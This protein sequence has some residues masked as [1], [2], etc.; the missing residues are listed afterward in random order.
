MFSQVEECNRSLKWSIRCV[1]DA[2][3]CASNR[4]WEP[5]R[6]S[7]WAMIYWH[8]FGVLRW[9]PC[10]ACL[11]FRYII[12]IL[13][14]W[15]QLKSQRLWMISKYQPSLSLNASKQTALES[16]DSH[17]HRHFDRRPVRVPMLKMTKHE[18]WSMVSFWHEWTG[19]PL[20]LM[21]IKSQT[22][23]ESWWL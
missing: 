8:F 15:C 20:L 10:S 2:F 6:L 7:V 23:D 13:R 19:A 14:I 17:T 21:L 16:I 4:S 5:N 3:S 12:R 11:E 18:I 22:A 9:V 1:S